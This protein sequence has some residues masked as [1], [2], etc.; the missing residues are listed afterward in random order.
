MRTP[1]RIMLAAMINWVSTVS[2][3]RMTELLDA[4]VKQGVFRDGV[5]PINLYISISGLS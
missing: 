2:C 4:G 5:E 1:A 3:S